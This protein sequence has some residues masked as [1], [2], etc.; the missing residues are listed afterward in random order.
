MSN[1]RKKGTKI[2]K[3]RKKIQKNA[4]ILKKQIEKP[5]KCRLKLRK[6]EKKFQKITKITKKTIKTLKNCQKNAKNV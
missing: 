6:T 5:V 1:K 4:K 3:Y 2:G